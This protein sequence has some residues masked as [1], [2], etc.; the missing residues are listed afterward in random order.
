MDP[1]YQKLALALQDSLSH[2]S[3]S[4]DLEAIYNDLSTPPNPD[5]GHLTFP[6]FKLSKTFGEKPPQIAQKLANQ[7][8]QE[9]SPY[10]EPF[11]M[12]GPYL[13]V[14]FSSQALG[15][16]V[17]QTM[18]DGE[19]FSLQKR[20]ES[21]TV[22]EYSQP[23]THKDLHV[24]HMRNLCFGNALV[25]LLR[26]TGR[27]VVAA[28]YPGDVGTHVAKCLWFLKYHN[29]EAAPDQQ[30]GAWLGSIYAQAHKKL[31]DERG[32]DQEETNRQQLTE[33]LKALKNQAGEF[34]ELWVKTREWSIEAM[35][36]IYQWADVEFD[37]W[38]FES[39]VDA[40]SVAWVK[41][42]YEAGQL[43]LSEGAIGLD[44]N[45]KK[46]GFCLLLKSDGN[47]LYATKDLQL[48]RQKFM[49]HN[50]KQSLYIVDMRQELHFK[51]VF[52]TL[53]HLGFEGAKNCKHL[54][55]N[56]VELPDGAM[57][58]RKG[59]VVPIHLLIKEMRRH[60]V[61]NYL[62]RYIDEWSSDE[63]WSIADQVAQGAI[64]Y[65]M[66][67]MELNKKIV[68]DLKEWLKL[69]GESGP[70][71]QYA[72][73]R[74]CSLQNKISTEGHE[75]NYS[76]LKLPAETKLMVKLAQ[77]NKTV[78]SCAQNLRT[79]NLC[80]YLY[81]LAKDFNSFYHD[82]PIAKEKNEP[83]KAARLHLAQATGQTLKQGLGLLGIPAPNKM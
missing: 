9:S 71:I 67:V 52:A 39:Q 17:V 23:N 82:C 73:A 53:E 48:A 62:N 15:E 66:N 69:D 80:T 83:L 26:Y 13:N 56:F 25:R 75:A 70:Y 43:Q 49:D 32:S 57:S 10:F 41:E 54:K 12:A 64:K 21:P 40:P 27:P 18:T 11:Q 4:L 16:L 14:T 77:F 8:N 58:S 46:M 68:F 30:K 28:T 5:L 7:L 36:E 19:L 72:H 20:N 31:E 61:E 60:V 47:G 81:E 45:E 37:E 55:Y 29:Q 38:Y 6:C 34:Y 78:E 51:Q 76:E 1:L 3:V 50:P 24:G 59:N 44:L 65:G 63:I 35:K 79:S 42:L 2:F 22:I 74:I 33:I